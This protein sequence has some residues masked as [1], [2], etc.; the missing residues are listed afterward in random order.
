MMVHFAYLKL[1][2]NIESEGY[3]K[4]EKFKFHCFSNSEG[5]YIIANCFEQVLKVV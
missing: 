4:F 5:R 2:R 1:G 3:L